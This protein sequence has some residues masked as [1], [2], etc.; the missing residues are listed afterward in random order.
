MTLPNTFANET[1]PQMQELDENDAALSA[2]GTIPCVASGTN[3]LTMTP[4]PNKSADLTA[5]ANYIRL[6]GIAAATNTA[7][8]TAQYPG[9]SALPVYKDSSSGPVALTGNEII[10]G[11]AFTLVYDS[12]LNGGNGGFHLNAQTSVFGSQTLTGTL[13]IGTT[14]A[15]GALLAVGTIGTLGFTASVAPATISAASLVAASLVSSPRLS[16]ST[17]AS[18]A[19]LAVGATVSSLTRLLNTQATL[20]YG[21]LTPNALQDVALTLPGVQIL[22]TV[23]LGLPTVA[24]GLL[25]NAFVP[26]AGTVNVRAAN[27]QAAATIVAFT[28]TLRATGMGFS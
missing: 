6:S 23:H 11:C 25:F 21:A 9:L 14:L 22:D 20:A 8:V 28:V 4:I 10:S 13:Q 24:A 19:A 15:P 1:A 12:A 26:A 17:L 3:A 5:Y 7:S 2:L 18:V 27:I 16:A